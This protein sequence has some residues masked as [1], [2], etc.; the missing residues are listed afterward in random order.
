[1]SILIK[2]FLPLSFIMFLLNQS[3]GSDPPI[4]GTCKNPTALHLHVQSSNELSVKIDTA[5]NTNATHYQVHLFSPTSVGCDAS[6]QSNGIYRRKLNNK[7]DNMKF[8][9]RTLFT[10]PVHGKSPGSNLSLTYDIDSVDTCMSMCVAT[11]ATCKAVQYWSNVKHCYQFDRFYESNFVPMGDDFPGVS[12]NKL[13]VATAKSFALLSSGAHCSSYTNL[14]VAGYWTDGGSIEQ[15]YLTMLKYKNI[16]NCSGETFQYHSGAGDCGCGKDACKSQTTDSSWNIYRTY[17][18]KVKCLHQVD[19]NG[20]GVLP[21]PS[22]SLSLYTADAYACNN[23]GCSSGYTSV[24]TSVPDA[25]TSVELRVVGEHAL[26]LK[27]VGPEND[28]GANITHYECTICPVIFGE[29]LVKGGDFEGPNAMQYWKK[30]NNPDFAEIVGGFG[31]G[32]S[33]SFRVE[34]DRTQSGGEQSITAQLGDKLQVSVWTKIEHI[35]GGSP[36]VTPAY[37]RL[38]E[39]NSART[40]L[41]EV[42][43]SKSPIDVWTH[44]VKQFT[45]TNTFVG[46]ESGCTYSSDPCVCLLRCPQG[47][48]RYGDGSACS[49]GGL[50]NCDL[51]YCKNSPNVGMSPCKTS[52]G[53][54]LFGRSGDLSDGLNGATIRLLFDNVRIGRRLPGECVVLKVNNTKSLISV[55]NGSEK[56]YEVKIKSCNSFGCT[57]RLC[58]VFEQ[59]KKVGIK[60]ISAD[61]YKYGASP[62]TWNQCLEACRSTSSCSQTVWNGFSCYPTSVAS[63]VES[64]DNTVA[65]SICEWICPVISNDHIENS[66]GKYFNIMKSCTGLTSTF[67]NMIDQTRNSEKIWSGSIE[68]WPRANG[69]SGGADSHGRRSS[70]A[71]SSQW[72]V[73]DIISTPPGCVPKADYKTAH[74][75]SETDYRNASTSVP[76]RPKTVKLRVAGE[77]ALS[78]KIEPSG[79]FMTMYGRTSDCWNYTSQTISCDN[80]GLDLTPKSADVGEEHAVQCCGKIMNR[81][82]N[83][84]HRQ[85]SGSTLLFDTGAGQEDN[86]HVTN[87]KSAVQICSKV[88]LRLCTLSEVQNEE[89][90]GSRCYF[91]SKL[92]W[93][94][95]A[96]AE[97]YSNDDGGANVSHYKVVFGAQWMWGK[98]GQSCTEVCD[99][100]HCDAGLISRANRNNDFWS[101]D[102]VDNS[103]CT[104][105]GDGNSIVH[106]S[107]NSEQANTAQHGKC[108]LNGATDQDL[109]DGQTGDKSLCNGKLAGFA[110][111]CPCSSQYNIDASFGSF[112]LPAGNKTSMPLITDYGSGLF[113]ITGSDKIPFSVDVY[114]CNSIG[115]S[116][117]PITASTSAPDKPKSV[118]LRVKDSNSLNIKIEQPDDDGGANI[119]HFSYTQ[120]PTQFID[121]CYADP[122]LYK[123]SPGLS[124]S[125]NDNS[126]T[127]QALYNDG[128][129]RWIYSII[130]SNATKISVTL[131]TT[132]TST[133]NH[134]GV[135][136]N[137]QNKDNFDVVYLRLW[138]MNIAA[139][140]GTSIQYG[141]IRNGKI[142]F[143]TSALHSGTSLINRVLT[144]ELKLDRRT[145]SVDGEEMLTIVGNFENS[146]ARVGLFNALKSGNNVVF[147]NFLVLPEE[148]KHIL[149]SDAVTGTLLRGNNLGTAPISFSFKSCNSIGCSI[150]DT[151]AIITL[152]EK[153]KNVFLGVIGS[154]T[155]KVAIDPPD[156]DGGADVI[157]YSIRRKTATLVASAWIPSYEKYIPHNIQARGQFIT[158]GTITVKNFT[159]ITIECDSLTTR[160]HRDFKFYKNLTQLNQIKGVPYSQVSHQDE[161][162]VP[163]SFSIS[164]VVANYAEWHNAQ[165]G[166]RRFIIRSNQIHCLL[167]YHNVGGQVDNPRLGKWGRLWTNVENHLINLDVQGTEIT[168]HGIGKNTN[169]FLFQT[170]TLVGCST[171]TISSTTA[172]PCQPPS[173]YLKD[174]T[175][176]SCPPNTS[177]STSNAQECFYNDVLVFPYSLTTKINTLE[178]FNGPS[179]DVTGVV[180]RNVSNFWGNTTYA[181][182]SVYHAITNTSKV[183]LANVF[184][185]SRTYSLMQNTTNVFP[186][187]SS[188][189]STSK[190]AF[191]KTNIPVTK[192]IG[193]ITLRVSVQACI[194]ELSRK[195]CGKP[196]LTETRFENK[197]SPPPP[198]VVKRVRGRNS[199]YALNISWKPSIFKG[200]NV[201]IVRQKAVYTVQQQRVDIS[202]FWENVAVVKD[203][204]CFQIVT[205]TGNTDNG[206]LSV[207]LD[208]GSGFEDVTPTFKKYTVKDISLKVVT[209]YGFSEGN[210]HIECVSPTRARLVGTLQSPKNLLNTVDANGVPITS[211]HFTDIPSQCKPKPSTAVGAVQGP[212]GH[213]DVQFIQWYPQNDIRG[214]GVVASSPSGGLKIDE[215]WNIDAEYDLVDFPGNC[216]PMHDRGSMVFDKCFSKGTQL[217]VYNPTTQ[218]WIGSI[219]ANGIAM[220]CNNCEEL[221]KQ[222][223]GTSKISIDGDNSGYGRAPTNCMNGLVCHFT[224]TSPTT[225]TWETMNGLLGNQITAYRYRVQSQYINVNEQ[226]SERSP[227]SQASQ[228][229][230]VSLPATMPTLNSISNKPVTEGGDQVATSDNRYLAFQVSTT[231]WTGAPIINFTLRWLPEKLECGADITDI[232]LVDPVDTNGPGLV[233]A[234]VAVTNAPFIVKIPAL[235]KPNTKYH[236]FVSALALLSNASLNI[237]SPSNTEKVIL[238][239]LVG[240]VSKNISASRGNDLDCVK[241]SNT[242][243]TTTTFITPCKTI[244]YAI[245]NFPFESFEYIVEPGSYQLLI[246]LIFVAKRMKIYSRDGL[247]NNGAN[248]ATKVLCSSR[249]LDLDIGKK[250]FAPKLISGLHFI[251]DENDE[252][253]NIVDNGG[254]VF[255]ANLPSSGTGTGTGTNID[256]SNYFDVTIEHCIFEGFSALQSGGGIHIINVRARLKIFDVIFERNMATGT[257]GDG[258]AM[259]IDTS[260]NVVVKNVKCNSNRASH[261]GG[262][263][264]V[265]S[266][267]VVVVD[268]FVSHNDVAGRHGGAVYIGRSSSITMT[269]STVQSA[270]GSGAIYTSAAIVVLSKIAILD[271]ITSMDAAALM[272]VSS[273]LKINHNSKI[274]GTNGR[275]IK[276]NLCSLVI[277]NSLLIR[278]GKAIATATATSESSNLVI[279]NGAGIL[280]GSES[281]LTVTFSVF[282]QNMG[283]GD[284]GAIMCDRCVLFHISG[285]TFSENVAAR[286]GAITILNTPVD[287]SVV[288]TNFRHNKALKGGGGAI[289]RI[290]NVE[291]ELKNLSFLENSALYGADLAT[292]PIQ[293]VVQRGTNSDINVIQVVSNYLPISSPPIQV[294]VIDR[295]GNTVKDQGEINFISFFG[296]FSTL[297]FTYFF[298]VVY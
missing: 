116:T 22:A 164:K 254:A 127:V 32:G 88:G 258:G 235:L 196:T 261:F 79:K 140:G 289:Y 222:T 200:A 107:V 56:K 198:P 137:F 146:A 177:T 33:R 294:S 1:M 280:L 274:S 287:A 123:C 100:M 17:E 215:T 52:L 234:S 161:E 248:E 47:Q 71:S 210:L 139:I 128:I 25:P 31:R 43:I 144:V 109:R 14:R 290:G 218:G 260:T 46:K 298:A 59:S 98:D 82:G 120:K 243:T 134:P 87:F 78:L 159:S 292:D 2:W 176:W 118:H 272:C 142:N 252:N 282:Y 158:K 214:A 202:N 249:C 266:K 105:F 112:Y 209:S 168:E 149:V 50:P 10:N 186:S 138:N 263:L 11:G 205:G 85:I 15:C 162:N 8:T 6:A 151:I 281:E 103:H 51:G 95:T 53:V 86:C 184:K 171:E 270:S 108:Y 193:A 75:S 92:V 58:I 297:T 26:E 73:G 188:H 133:Y 76:S 220:T 288:S 69:G 110:R 199:S 126:W 221:Q 296:T 67:S 4:A 130:P 44:G 38:F 219:T 232:T 7:D 45:L 154:N 197:P 286:G 236:V 275:G 278:N 204:I 160:V 206:A 80:R 239:T 250:K 223:T 42:P 208:R 276:G 91:D 194:G 70:G 228:S 132:Q 192:Y 119:T 111:L 13:T 238:E 81:F 271:S 225:I 182:I 48:S 113:N 12:A 83:F 181:R 195:I 94:S 60:P 5:G 167:P 175:C 185:S 240:G 237:L 55:V 207:L 246:P 24:S 172:P 16:V 141:R 224:Y 122:G 135:V 233:S 101:S 29:N 64:T 180:P 152:P 212:G 273:S 68:L 264:S 89:G 242:N 21:A 30:Y 114:R 121:H 229:K 216:C 183:T 84:G 284:G 203:E 262:C 9:T 295:Y 245:Q 104:S 124:Y 66:I 178:K 57:K 99:S 170:C 255:L 147:N 36:G 267:S 165:T 191:S 279:M 72:L 136:F 23:K 49:G 77:S 189:K 283:N 145:I 256:D 269:N 19:V 259:V 277:E 153:P 163:G 285:S 169:L 18:E 251:S 62:L 96:S 41:T 129:E 155:I 34:T 226:I 247:I 3:K 37:L 28:G 143:D 150:D 190:W 61:G 39:D 268:N 35:A 213:G 63:I 102:V 179:I 106:P 257:K 90:A 93:T 131:S 241:S 265:T 20:A 125:Q 117:A 27:M 173:A 291:V 201:P 293:V 174:D 74:C 187:S 211:W 166:Y 227:F 156:E 244:S 217:A 40:Y 148:E 157:F 65:G 97:P 230:T 115:C 231:G 54:G 253:D